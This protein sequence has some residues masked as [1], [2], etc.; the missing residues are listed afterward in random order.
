MAALL[1]DVAREEGDPRT[2]ARALTALAFVH[3]HNGSRFDVAIEEAQS[4]NEL[5]RSA[6]D[7]L[8][9][10]WSSNISGVIALYQN[11]NDAGEVHLTGAIENFR[12][13]GDRPGEASALCNLSRVH[14]ATGRTETAVELA[15]QARRC[16]TTWGTP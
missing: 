10:C 2:E 15:R 4:A 13:L 7:P 5:A 8:T 1:R 11:R 9:A 3:Q 16:T 6:D 14:L 12:A